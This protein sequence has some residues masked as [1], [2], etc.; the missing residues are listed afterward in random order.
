MKQKM[1][2][3]IAD[4]EEII[5]NGLEFFFSSSDLDI[6]IVGIFESGQQTIEYLAINGA[7][8]VLT[9]VNM[10]NKS[11]L[12]VAAYVHQNMPDV[13][14]V[15]ISGYHEF[16]YAQSAIEYG[17]SSYLLK[18]VSISQLYESFSRLVKEINMEREA[19]KAAQ[20]EKEQYSILIPTLQQQ[21]LQNLVYQQSETEAE[22][23]SEMGRL[24]FGGNATK[25]PFSV[26]ELR[27]ISGETFHYGKD[28]LHLALL[29]F[30]RNSKELQFYEKTG[31]GDTA[32]FFSYQKD[33]T[34]KEALLYVLDALISK[35]SVSFKEVFNISFIVANLKVFDDIIA[36]RQ[37]LICELESRERIEFGTN[38]GGKYKTETGSDNTIQTALQ[39][40]QRNYGRD[41]SLSEVAD[42]MHLN[43]MYF[44]RLFKQETGKSYTDYLTYLRIEEAKRM[45]RDGRSRIF[46]VGKSVGYIND[47]FF[48]RI[49]KKNMGMTPLE[50][51]KRFKAK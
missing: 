9:D 10:T 8:I 25:K 37:Y 24:G 40:I 6:E 34:T 28:R 39:Y 2:L 4:D 46:E 3:V 51:R 18:P 49:F 11:G 27:I 36:L 23:E 12:D 38:D 19:R 5:R 20:R 48:I 41:I 22:L 1:R 43:T 47:K 21:F 33:T 31:V 26:F 35:A 17:V 7:D 44:G 14:V 50:Y 32:A 45:L 29:N 16:K 30:L 42:I 15:I 13:H